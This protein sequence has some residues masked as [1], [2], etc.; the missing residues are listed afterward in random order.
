[1]KRNR[2]FPAVAACATAVSAWATPAAAAW[3]NAFGAGARYQSVSEYNT[4]GNRTVRELGWLPGVEARLGY[5]WQDWTLFGEAD[6]YGGTLDYVGST[7]S[8]QPYGSSTGTQ[9]LRL[10]SGARY[11]FTPWLAAQAAV[12]WERWNRDIRGS[13]SV[14]GLQERST[15]TRLLLG[16]ETTWHFGPGRL[17]ADAAVVFSTPERLHVGFS[18]VLDEAN[19]Q[20]RSS[21]GVRFGIAFRPA[22]LPSLELRAQADWIRVGRSEPVT[23]SIGG[24]PVGTVAQP[25]HVKQSLTLSARYRF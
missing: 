3:D 14:A 20:T 24:R 19:F 11:A 1:M 7:Q 22:A 8:G 21:T 16:G 25:E 4:A 5:T 13:A 23:A 10:R 6:F 9:F 17:S 15:S 12:E 18:G 2:I